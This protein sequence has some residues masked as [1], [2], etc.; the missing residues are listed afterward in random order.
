MPEGVTPPSLL[1]P[2][3]I[4]A[5][6]IKSP[7][8]QPPKGPLSLLNTHSRFNLPPR[9]IF[10]SFYFL[11][12]FSDQI[13]AKTITMICYSFFSVQVLEL[14]KFQRRI[15]SFSL[16]YFFLLTPVLWLCPSAHH[17]MLTWLVCREC[18]R[19]ITAYH[20]NIYRALTHRENLVATKREIIRHLWQF[21]WKWVSQKLALCITDSVTPLC[22]HSLNVA[23]FH[24]ICFSNL[25]KLKMP[26]MSNS[27][28]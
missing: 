28:L 21:Y 10:I 1:P 13:Y 18:C 25:P 24:L 2:A 14:K 26:H 15:L 22:R 20:D 27:C 16:C 8:Q 6:W 11:I 4:S 17:H 5:G 3:I 23:L 9:S 12:F 7:P 19:L